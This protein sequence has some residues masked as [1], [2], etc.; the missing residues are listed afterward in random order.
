MGPEQLGGHMLL[1]L[2]NPVEVGKVVETTFKTDLR[3]RPIG[4]N[5]HT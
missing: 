4:I 3:N 2:E 1:F 5:Q